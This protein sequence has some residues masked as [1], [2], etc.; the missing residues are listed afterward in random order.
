[1]TE[2]LKLAEGAPNLAWGDDR[3]DGY[4]ERFHPYELAGQQAGVIDFD[5]L[6]F[7]QACGGPAQ[8]QE[9]EGRRP[10]RSPRDRG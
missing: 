5:V 10:S 8:G 6:Q 2:E 9:D 3:G 4:D 7:Q 1:M